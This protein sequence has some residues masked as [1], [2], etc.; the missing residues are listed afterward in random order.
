MTL[1]IDDTLEE[2]LQRKAARPL[3]RRT[4]WLLALLVL[5]AGALGCYGYLKL[6]HEPAMERLEQQR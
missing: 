3:R 5:A 2:E 6:V 1:E 4:A